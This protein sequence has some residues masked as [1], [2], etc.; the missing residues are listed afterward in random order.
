M[1]RRGGDVF[2]APRGRDVLAFA[3][4]EQRQDAFWQVL[5]EKETETDN[6]KQHWYDVHTGA[7]VHKHNDE[8]ASANK[9]NRIHIVELNKSPIKTR[10][11]RSK[12]ADE[13]SKDIAANNIAMWH[14]VKSPDKIRLHK[15]VHQAEQKNGGGAI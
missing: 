11:W 13:Q 10:G 1:V 5:S 7:S 2:R 8:A 3:G 4:R 12:E 15:A 6:T 9:G 14:Y